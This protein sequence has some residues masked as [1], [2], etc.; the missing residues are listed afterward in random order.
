MDVSLAMRSMVPE[1]D[2]MVIA[3][4]GT[5]AAML[6]KWHEEVRALKPSKGALAREALGQVE[7]RPASPLRRRGALRGLR[8]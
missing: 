1:H 4:S 2:G 7:S 6:A 8:G 3:C 5:S